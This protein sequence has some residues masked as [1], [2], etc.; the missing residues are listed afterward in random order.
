MITRVVPSD[1]IFAPGFFNS[2]D[3]TDHSRMLFILCN[4]ET[5]GSSVLLTHIGAAFCRSIILLAIE[6]IDAGLQVDPYDGIKGTA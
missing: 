5:R 4:A 6:M 1:M 2:R 3:V